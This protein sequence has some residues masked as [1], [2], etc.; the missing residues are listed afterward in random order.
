MCLLQQLLAVVE[1][2]YKSGDLI[3]YKL[4]IVNENLLFN[5]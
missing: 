3:N 1:S 5:L 2:L 4:M